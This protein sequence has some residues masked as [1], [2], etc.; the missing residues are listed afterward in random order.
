MLRRGVPA[1][2]YL[3]DPGRST[4]IPICNAL[5]NDVHLL[6]PTALHESREWALSDAVGG[7]GCRQLC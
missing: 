2:K 4:S 6:I 3:P 5:E 1:V 7:G